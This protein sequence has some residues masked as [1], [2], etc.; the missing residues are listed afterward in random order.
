MDS[1]QGT[2]SAGG[3]VADVEGPREDE[4]DSEVEESQYSTLRAVIEAIE[5]VVDE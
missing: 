3:S 1:L 2:S 4:W 5:E